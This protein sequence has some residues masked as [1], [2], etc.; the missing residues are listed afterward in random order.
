MG[1]F[2]WLF[3]KKKQNLIQEN[4]ICEVYSKDGT[5][6][7]RFNLSNG[8]LDGKFEAF[9]IHG[10]VFLILNF[11]NGRLHGECSEYSFSRNCM[12]HVEKFNDGKLIYKQRCKKVDGHDSKTLLGSRYELDSP[13][14]DESILKKEGSFIKS[15][16]LEEEYGQIFKLKSLGVNFKLLAD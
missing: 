2:D 13:I 5:I 9:T 4:G 15:W 11:K 14:T 8:L 1:I 16:H 3:G 12:E 7:S 6:S 10:E